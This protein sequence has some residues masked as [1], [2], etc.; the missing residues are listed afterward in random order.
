MLHRIVAFLVV[1]INIF[2][3]IKTP[4]EDIA[5]RKYLRFG[6]IILIVQS[7]LGALNVVYNFPTIMSVFHLFLSVA[8]IIAFAHFL[9]PDEGYEKFEAS[10][11]KSKGKDF[12]NILI[13]MGVGQFFLGGILK[14][15][16]ARPLCHAGQGIKLLCE[17]A[18]GELSYWPVTL[19]GKL[20]ALHYYNGI[21]IAVVFIT[22]AIYCF[23]MLRYAFE[24]KN[25]RLAG[26]LLTIILLGANHWI[27]IHRML[28]IEASKIPSILHMI[29]AILILITLFALRFWFKKTELAT[30]GVEKPTV[31][32]DMFELTKPRLGLL[33]IATIVSGILLTGKFI[34]FFYLSFALFLSA[35]VVAS[36]TTLN[37][38]MEKEVDAKMERTKDRALPSGRLSPTIALIQG[39]VLI[40][41][42]IPLLVVYVN[43][44]TAI[45]GF[46]A[47]ALYLFAYTPMKRKSPLALYVGAIPGAIPPVMGRTIVVGHIDTFGW[48]LFAVLFI[49][50]LP[51]FMAISIYHNDDYMTGGIKVYSHVLSE[52]VLKIL[53]LLLT[54][55]LA[56]VSVLPYFYQLSSF[57]YLIASSVLGIAFTLQSVMGFFTK[58]EEKYIAW[59]RQ[60]FWGSIIYLPLLMA[61]MIF[62]S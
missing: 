46:V 37:C 15:T 4:K 57:S 35:L 14:N 61:A 17:N 52:K 60:Y 38:W 29:Y 27:G 13:L 9:F 33:V 42:S 7:I 34:D 20:Q 53:I 11:Y 18:A 54:I 23:S 49:W 26:L 22:M 36:A 39:L 45:L 24:F 44:D 58:S 31:L 40:G 50:Q 1:L 19:A 28:A 12:V 2:L 55:V 56:A 59:A 41:V 16:V 32:G 43:V 5:Q 21:A 25:K 6:L 51:H 10:L 48:I 30:F 47:F 3:L 62:L 8:Y